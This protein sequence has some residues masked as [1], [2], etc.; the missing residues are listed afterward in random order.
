MSSVLFLLAYV[1]TALSNSYEF[2]FKL[3]PEQLSSPCET[4]LIDCQAKK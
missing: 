4:M 2:V 1:D 3:S